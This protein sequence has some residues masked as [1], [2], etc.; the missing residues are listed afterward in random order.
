MVKRKKGRVKDLE[1]S[2]EGCGKVCKSKGALVQHQKRKQQASLRGKTNKSLLAMKS[3]ELLIFP[4]VFVP[5]N[6]S[7]KELTLILS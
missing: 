4:V 6:L 1:Y 7:L 2:Y 5:F 3:M